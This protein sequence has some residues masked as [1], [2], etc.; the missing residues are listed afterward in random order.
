MP[1]AERRALVAFAV[2]TV[3]AIGFFAAY[4]VDAS[5][6]WLGLGLALALG[7]M[8]VGLVSWSNSIDHGDDTEPRHRLEPTPEEIEAQR[9]AL[10]RGTE[11]LGRR[12]VLL[13]A[14]GAAIVSAVAMMAAPLRS[15]GPKPANLRSSPWKAGKRLVTSNGKPIKANALPSDALLTAYPEGDIAD[16]NGPVLVMKLPETGVTI[17]TQQGAVDGRVVAY[18]KICTHAGCAVGQYQADSRDPKTIHRLQCPCHQS[19]FDPSD[20]AKPVGGPATRP[21]PQLG[22]GTDEDGNLIATTELSAPVG[23]ASWD[24]P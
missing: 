15:L 19:E 18:S 8:G 3:G 2:S 7:G 23:P 1:S 10:S 5:H 12:K 21:L 11:L 4:W 6:G 16:G 20:G 14:A 17:R 9:E 22:L 24:W 13:A